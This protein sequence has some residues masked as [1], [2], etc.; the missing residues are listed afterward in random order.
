MAKIDHWVKTAWLC[1]AILVI[2]TYALQ[3]LAS[4][5]LPQTLAQ[6]S[7]RLYAVLFALSCVIAAF[8]VMQSHSGEGNK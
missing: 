4:G 6:I 1:F 7:F 5:Y 2:A 8:R 3:H